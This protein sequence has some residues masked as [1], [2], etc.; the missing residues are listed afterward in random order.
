MIDFFLQEAE[1]QAQATLSL[2][3][4][5]QN[6]IITGGLLAGSMLCAHM[7]ATHESGFTVG[8]YVLF[9][10]YIMQLYNPLNWLGTYYK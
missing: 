6:F 10:S 3:N 2:L 4:F 9:A 8:D 1:W 7:V 5:I